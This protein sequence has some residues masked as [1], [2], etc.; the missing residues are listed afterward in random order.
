[1]S[2]AGGDASD[3]PAIPEG[4]NVNR[5]KKRSRRASDLPP[6]PKKVIAKS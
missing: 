6:K 2:E 4:D 3:V 1:M 5:G